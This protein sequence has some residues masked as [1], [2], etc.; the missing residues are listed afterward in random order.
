QSSA[1]TVLGQAVSTAPSRLS[2][3]FGITNIKID[4]MVQGIVTNTPQA[5]LTVEQQVSRDL[6]VTYVTNLSQTA[7][8]VFRVEWALNRQ[9]SV[10]AVR[11]ENGEFGIDIQYKK[12]FR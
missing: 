6:T 10:V 9:Y 1:G 8:Q 7:E 4:P 3:L 5:R 11:D 12:R 2:K